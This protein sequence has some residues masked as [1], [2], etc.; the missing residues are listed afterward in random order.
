MTTSVAKPPTRRPRRER[1][2]M[3]RRP[4]P[5]S[6]SLE[7]ATKILGKM[8]EIGTTIPAERMIV[9]PFMDLREQGY[10]VHLYMPGKP[11]YSYVFCLSRGSAHVTVYEGKGFD[12]YKNQPTERAYKA[13]TLFGPGPDQFDNA[14]AHI[15]GRME[16]RYFG[17]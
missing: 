13:E 12:L 3:P 16:K 14:A 2:N 17:R 1:K 4:L 9:Q 5:M 7:A 11:T 10:C 8:N 15:I 6:D